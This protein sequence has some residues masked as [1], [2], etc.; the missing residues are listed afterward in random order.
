VPVDES[1][2]KIT[3]ALTASHHRDY[4][5]KVLERTGHG[6]MVMRSDEP[7]SPAVPMSVAPEYFEL[8]ETWLRTHGFCGTDADR[9]GKAAR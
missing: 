6:M 4:Q 3:Q 7:Q 2:E 8:L 5:V 1:V 9:T